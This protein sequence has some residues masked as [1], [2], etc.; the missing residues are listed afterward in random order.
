[1]KLYYNRSSSSR[2]QRYGQ[3][4]QQLFKTKIN[5]YA[6]SSIT[7]LL[8]KQANNKIHSIREITANLFLKLHEINK[9]SLTEMLRWAFIIIL[10]R[11]TDLYELL[12]CYRDSTSFRNKKLSLLYADIIEFVFCFV[13]FSNHVNGFVWIQ[14]KYSIKFNKFCYVENVKI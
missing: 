7:S 14:E 4:Q 2:Q 5:T 10:H 1:M 8:I 13:K 6:N 11:Y 3:Q 12:S 9:I